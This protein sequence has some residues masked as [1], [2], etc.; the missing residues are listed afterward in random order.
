[1][2]KILALTAALLVPSAA[3]AQS[4]PQPIQVMVVGAFHF[5]NPGKDLN[6]STIDPVTTPQKQAELA[7]VAEGLRRFHPTAIAVER[8]ARDT[9]TLLDHRYPAFTP[10]DLLTNPDERVQI[11]YRLANLE[12]L[13]RV[14]AIDEVGSESERDYF[15][16]DKVKAWIDAHGRQAEW[17][18]LNGQVAAMAT[19]LTA[20][21]RTE[22]LGTLLANENRSDNP[23]NANMN[24][25]YGLLRF[26]DAVDQP[27]AELNAAWYERNAK[28]F[29]KLMLVAR[30]G[31]RIVIVYGA[32]HLYWLRHFIENTPGFELVEPTPYLAGT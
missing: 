10:A 28:I 11:A 19:D 15:P 24:F 22:T 32:G 26:G 27:G 21:Q 14:Y 31:D 2:L 7:A 9:T 5:D 3:L 16:F 20:R 18:A 13:E 25:Y 17:E 23:F 1:M 30:P 8:D 29:G 4:A 6:N 12:G